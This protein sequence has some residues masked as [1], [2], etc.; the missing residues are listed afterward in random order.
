MA[1]HRGSG[2]GSIYQAK[3]GRW[4]GEISL[5]FKP[6]GK[7]HR[8]IVYGKTRVEVASSLSRLL[9][10]KD[11]GIPIDT[12]KQTLEQFLTDWL[13]NTVKPSC[14]VKTYYTYEYHLRVHIVPGLGRIPLQKLSPQRLQDFL[15][16]R[17]HSGLSVATI[18]HMN[19]TLRSALSQACKWQLVPQNAAKLIT[20][21]RGV[22]YK[23]SVLTPDQ[24][25]AFLSSIAGTRYEGLYTTAL[26]TGLRRGELLGL[27]WSDID[28]E[29]GMLQVNHSLERVKGSGLRLA[30]PKSATSKRSLRMLRSALLH[31]LGTANVRPTNGNGLVANGKN[32]TLFSRH[33]SEQPAHLNP[34]PNPLHAC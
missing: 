13:K 8:K 24:A 34:S 9:R 6:D 11:K 28:F 12:N 27:R 10:D 26:T 33:V 2:E 17:H 31:Y 16:E 23:A 32:K 15:N 4:R 5:G 1:K 22:R 29:K 20:L 18:K 3:D 21:P 7:A 14:R 30:D 19:E 25:K